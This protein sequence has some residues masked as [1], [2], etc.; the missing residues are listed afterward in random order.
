MDGGVLVSIYHTLSSNRPTSQNCVTIRYINWQR[1]IVA[2]FHRGECRPTQIKWN[3][4][5]YSLTLVVQLMKD[6]R[7][8]SYSSRQF[9]SPCVY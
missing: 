8:L 7:I 3:G 4:I 6:K 2:Q 9:F 1:Y 5:Q